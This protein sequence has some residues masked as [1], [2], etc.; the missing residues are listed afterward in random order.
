MSHHDSLANVLSTDAAR[1]DVVTGALAP[2]A[3]RRAV[4]A[5]IGDDVS[6]LPSSALLIASID[7]E[8]SEALQS[9]PARAESNQ[10]LRVVTD[11]ITGVLRAT[12]LLGRVD[13]DTLGILMPSTPA[14]QTAPVC[15]R[16]RAVVSECSPRHGMP[17]TISI[18]VASPRDAQPWHSARAA[19]EQARSGG[20]DTT[21]IAP[22][23]IPS[24][25]RR[26]A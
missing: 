8:V 18:G 20:G 5:W 11:L 22:D 9:R 6:H 16:I 17:L 21:V 10:G 14:Q 26:A 24:V 15:R 12:D 3:F 7:W 4:D 25:Q 19:L 23:A 13:D 2:A 1:R